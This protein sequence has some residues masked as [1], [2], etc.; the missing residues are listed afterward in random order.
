MATVMENTIVKGRKVLAVSRKGSSMPITIEGDDNNIYFLKLAGSLSGPLAHICD[1]ISCRIGSAIE[2]PTAI[3][4]VVLI[5]DEIDTGP[6]DIEMKDLL[7]KSRGLNLAY[8]FYENVQDCT[9]ELMAS[10]T[11]LLHRLFIFDL[12]LL[13]IDRIASN[14]NLLSTEGRI[15]SFDYESS[16]L[17][18]GIIQHTS[19]FAGP[20]VLKQLR[21]NPLFSEHITDDMVRSEFQRLKQVPLQNIVESLP[22][23]WIQQTGQPTRP[24][25][26]SLVA[27]LTEAVNSEEKYVE[28][29]HTLHTVPFE[30]EEERKKRVRENRLKFKI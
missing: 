16:F 24:F 30:S 8:P 3:P 27:G 12:F 23:E 10:Q 11:E 26:E 14:T 21:H 29:L 1:W 20:L 22:E 5:H 13:N 4:S 17:I 7:R 19:Y 9:P 15:I 18:M 6:L 28:L 2:L 25:I